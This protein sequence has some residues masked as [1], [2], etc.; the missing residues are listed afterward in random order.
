MEAEQ[1]IVSLLN[2]VVVEG[3]KS[4]I[5]SADDM[6]SKVMCKLSSY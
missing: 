2:K 1:R 4:G 5:D 3:I 6:L